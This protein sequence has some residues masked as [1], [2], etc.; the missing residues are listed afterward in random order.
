MAKVV[1]IG[2]GFAGQTA[3]LYL[4]SA[5][6][7]DHEI[8]L[9]NRSGR[10]LYVPSL[11]WVGIDRMAPEKTQ[12]DLAPV[13]KRMNVNF[14]HGR[15]TEVHPDPNDEYVIVEPKGNG[16]GPLRLDY[17][18]LIVSTGPYLNFEGTSGLGPAHG[19]SWSICNVGHAVQCRDNYLES[20]ARMEK[21]EKQ[22]M[23]IGTGHP[24]ATCQGAA[25]EYISNIHKDLIRRNLRDKAELVW[26]SNERALGDFGVKGVNVRQKGRAYSSEDFLKAVFAEYGIEDQVRRGVKEVQPGK[27]FWEDFEG[28]EGETDF[29]FAMLIP[30]FKG[31]PLKWLGAGGEDVSEKVVNPAGLVLVDGIYGLPYPQLEETPDAWPGFYQNR[32]YRNIFAAGIAFAP[33][34]PISVPHTTPKGTVMAAAPPRTGMVSGIIGRVVARNVIDLIKHGRMTHHERMTE[35]YAACIASM[36]D[37]LWDG[38]A[39]TIMIYPVVPDPLRFPKDGGR[40]A[41]VTHMEMGLAGAWMKRLIHTT[42]IHKLQGRFGWKMIPE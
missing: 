36:G 9:V 15:A 4:G 13:C 41:F 19:N 21:G 6:G 1:I 16:D 26:L 34:G 20:V 3:A 32:N 11:V 38:S 5:L 24:G 12:F 2:A 33:P 28:N 25:F 31:V 8:T 17:D 14:V 27:A 40:D 23:V 10:F 22:R 7:K 18:H 37:S 30:Q 29:D 35:M 39:A 42:F